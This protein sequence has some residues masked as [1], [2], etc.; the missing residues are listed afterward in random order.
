[1]SALLFLKHEELTYE[2]LAFNPEEK[3]DFTEKIG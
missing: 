2:P 1:M 3:F